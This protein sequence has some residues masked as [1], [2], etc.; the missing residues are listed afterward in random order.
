MPLAE[1]P[2]PVLR[3]SLSVVDQDIVTFR[4]TVFDNITLWD[5]SIDDYQVI[6]ACRDAGIHDVIAS[7]KDGYQSMMAP[8]GRNFSGGQLQRMEIARVLAGDPTIIILDEATSALDNTT[9]RHV[10]ES[11]DSLHC[12]RV[13]VAHRLFTVRNCDRILVVDEGRI[14]EEGSYEELLARGGLFTELVKR[15]MLETQS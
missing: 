3:G 1:V 4:G 13:V 12:T 10:S 7:R 9:Q 2:R 8:R 15:Q 5:S 11:L 6:L 14:A